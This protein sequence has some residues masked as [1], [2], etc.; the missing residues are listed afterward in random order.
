MKAEKGIE[1][2]S[3]E[4]VATFIME[5][6]GVSYAPSYVP[7]LLQDLGILIRRPPSTRGRAAAK[8]GLKGSRSRR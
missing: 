8:A 4:C 3:A 7:L 5:R 1:T 6:F 2:R